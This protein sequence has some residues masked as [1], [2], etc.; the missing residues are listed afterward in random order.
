[1]RLIR[2][3]E[4]RLEGVLPGGN[5]NARVE[6][7]FAFAARAHGA[8]KYGNKPYSYHLA[9]TIACAAELGFDSDEHLITAA[10]H[11]VLEDTRTTRRELEQR[12]GA[13]I[14]GDVNEVSRRRGMVHA[15]YF[16]AM[17]PLAFAVKLADRLSNLREH[18]RGDARELARQR[19]HLFP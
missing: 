11:D 9:R 14:A 12:Y 2:I 15:H 18:G 8:Q 3:T 17:G 16:G 4:K 6:E 19:A 5:P 7:A 1:M 10:L 13:A